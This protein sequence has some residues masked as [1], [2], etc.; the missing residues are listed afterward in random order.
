MTLREKIEKLRAVTKVKPGY[1]DPI[2]EA[3]NKGAYEILEEVLDLIDEE[4]IKNG[5][6]NRT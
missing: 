5:N 4:E 2:C 1:D 6:S 3:E